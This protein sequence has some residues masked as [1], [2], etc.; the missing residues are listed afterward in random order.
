VFAFATPHSNIGE[1]TDYI[2]CVLRFTQPLSSKFREI[3][4]YSCEI[5]QSVPNS[6]SRKY[7]TFKVKNQPLDN[8]SLVKSNRKHCKITRRFEVDTEPGTRKSAVE[9]NS[10]FDR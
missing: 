7:I 6:F 2:E 5:Q 8:R 3:P 10:T 1:I 9:F 4:I